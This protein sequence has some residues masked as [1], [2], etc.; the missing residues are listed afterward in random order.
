MALTADCFTQPYSGGASSSQPSTET[1]ER[2][3]PRPILHGEHPVRNERQY[4]VFLSRRREFE[5][6][7]NVV[8]L[9]GDFNSAISQ[10]MPKLLK[11]D[12]DV[13]ISLKMVMCCQYDATG[14]SLPCDGCVVRLL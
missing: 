3:E 4:D 7:F 14:L 8:C 11:F 12:D 9:S 13:R 1:A 5:R 10:G 2:N 6:Y